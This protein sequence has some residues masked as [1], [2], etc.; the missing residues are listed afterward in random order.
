[1]T[2]T[3]RIATIAGL[4]ALAAPLVPAQWS[5]RENEMVIYAISKAKYDLTQS[6]Q[7]VSNAG[8]TGFVIQDSS[9]LPSVPLTPEFP[10]KSTQ[11][12]HNESN[13]WFGLITN[14]EKITSPRQKNISITKSLY[15]GGLLREAN[16]GSVST[17]PLDATGGLYIPFFPGLTQGPDF[18]LDQPQILMWNPSNVA[19]PFVAVADD[20]PSDFGP[21]G[22]TGVELEAFSGVAA[23]FVPWTPL[24]VFY[25]QQTFPQGVDIKILDDDAQVG[26][27]TGLIRFR[28]GRST[29]Q[30]S[31]TTNTH[32][33]VL[34]GSGLV[35]PAGGATTAIPGGYYLFVPAGYSI[36][37]TNPVPYSGPGAPK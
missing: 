5:G 21:A 12:L 23:F 27:R 36:S 15:L 32:L 7:G 19:P 8:K 6:P 24:K 20:A 11:V 13:D 1:M 2:T 17:K 31:F 33:F 16:T 3:Q 14:L 10:A 18:A 30:F 29:G 34:E 37:I 28:P 4:V 9:K 26:N 22:L 25:P 35:Q